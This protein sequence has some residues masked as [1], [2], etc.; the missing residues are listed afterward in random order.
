[1][2]VR[3]IVLRVSISFTKEKERDNQGSQLYDNEDFYKRQV[4]VIIG[5]INS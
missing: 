3:W 5:T 4:F 1:M 2:H